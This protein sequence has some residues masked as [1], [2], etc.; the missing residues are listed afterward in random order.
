MKNKK[1]INGMLLAIFLSSVASCKISSN[2]ESDFSNNSDNNISSSN[3]ENHT[4]EYQDVKGID[5]LNESGISYWQEIPIR[6]QAQADLNSGGEGC[7][8]P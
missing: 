4:V 3:I 2:I 1:I 5:A 7:Q 8:W 6:N